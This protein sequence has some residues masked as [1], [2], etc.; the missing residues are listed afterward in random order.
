L[1]RLRITVSQDGEHR[2]RDK[3]LGVSGR[4]GQ[5]RIGAEDARSSGRSDD[6]RQLEVI[7]GGRAFVR[8]GVAIPLMQRQ[9][10]I[11]G[12]QVVT[13]DSTVYQ[14][15]NQGFY[16]V[17]RVN[18]DRVTLEIAPQ[19]DTPGHTRRLNTT[20]EG[21]IGEWINLGDIARNTERDGSGIA[22]VSGRNASE[23][24]NVRVRVEEAR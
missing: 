22:S 4:P 2:E 10:V 12:K 11:N 15:A 20:V 14:E 21:R 3:A 24:M 16:V 13:T 5:W 6:T 8:S 23:R 17:P 7:E 18:G 19:Y 9:T 1:R